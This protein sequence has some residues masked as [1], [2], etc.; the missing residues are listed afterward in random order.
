MNVSFSS[1]MDMEGH[2]MCVLEMVIWTLRLR[3]E[4]FGISPSIRPA[5]ARVTGTRIWAPWCL[6]E[7]AE[8]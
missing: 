6:F 4:S 1:G 3:E 2:K 8:L 7:E 5:A